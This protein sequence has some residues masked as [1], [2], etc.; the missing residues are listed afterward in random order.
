MIWKIVWGY[1]GVIEA[2]LRVNL[3]S[4]E[5]QHSTFG[6]PKV[7][8]LDERTCNLDGVHLYFGPLLWP[9]NSSLGTLWIVHDCPVIHSYTI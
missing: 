2:K 5:F 3:A 9:A 1:G 8:W 6:V 7:E 4:L